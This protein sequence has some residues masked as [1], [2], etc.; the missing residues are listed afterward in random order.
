MKYSKMKWRAEHFNGTDWDQRAEKNA[1]Y[2]LIDDPGTLPKPFVQP[3][4]PSAVKPPPSRGRLGLLRQRLKGSSETTRAQA[5]PVRRPGK[6]WADD[7][8]DQNGNNDYLLFSNIDYAHPEVRED[9]TK[10]GEWMIKEVGVNGFRLDAVQHFSYRFTRDWIQKVNAASESNDGGKSAFVVGEVWTG[11]VTR[12]QKWLDAVQHPNGPQVY[13]YDAPLVYNFSR[14]SEDLRMKS[15]NTD[16]RTIVRD[17]L[18]ERRPKAAVTLVTNHDTQPGQ[19][20]YTPMLRDL[21]PLWYAFILLTD[22]GYPCVFWGDLYGTKGPHAEP[23]AC[24]VAVGRGMKKSLLP[25]LMMCRKLFA[26]GDQTYYEDSAACIGWTRA[27]TNDRPGCAA[28]MSILPPTAK[29]TVM[30]MRIGRPGE[31]WVDVLHLVKNE[32]IIDAKGYGNFPCGGMSVAVF[33]EKGA[34]GTEKFPVR[35][36]LDV[37]G[38]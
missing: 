11:E 9:I 6:G 38:S 15:R 37:Y 27:G 16:L 18:L 5:A 19:A 10:W 7:V 13:A 23:P 36:D 4:R 12:L 22:Q 20:C 29:P 28:V 21:K 26:Y 32:V 35:F 34:D 31:V 30:K 17:S 3:R 14:V 33:V 2:K 1:M 24:L 25:D 8:D